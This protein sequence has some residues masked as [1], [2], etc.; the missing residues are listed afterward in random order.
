MSVDIP[1]LYPSQ[2]YVEQVSAA[3]RLCDG[4]LVVVDVIE[5]VC[6]Q[7][8]I[9]QPLKSNCGAVSITDTHCSKTGLE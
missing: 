3:V 1:S 5:G 6:T 7:V 4:A 8:R 2:L 9:K